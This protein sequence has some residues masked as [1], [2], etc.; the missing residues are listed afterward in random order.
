MMPKVLVFVDDGTIDV[1]HTPGVE[2]AVIVEGED[3]EIP[4]DWIGLSAKQHHSLPITINRAEM[5]QKRPLACPET[6]L[7]G[8]KTPECDEEGLLSN[9]EIKE[10]NEQEEATKQNITEFFRPDLMKAPY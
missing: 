10:L 2:V 8:T 6:Q 5:P 4:D 7:A 9:E 1:M 3:V